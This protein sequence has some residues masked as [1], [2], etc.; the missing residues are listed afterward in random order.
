VGLP[1]GWKFWGTPLTRADSTAAK[2]DAQQAAAIGA[3]QEAT[4]KANAALSFAPESRPVTVARDFVQEARS[5]LDQV[6]GAPKVGDEAAWRDLVARLLSE[7]EAIRLKAET[8]RREDAEEVASLSAKLAKLEVAKEASD[9]K[10]AEY[11]KDNERLADIVRKFYWIA[12]SLAVLWLLSQVLTF[13]ARFN[14][15]LAP[16]AGVVNAVVAPALARARARAVEGLEAVGAGLRE[17]RQ[18]MG[19][20]VEQ[21]VVYLDEKAD[22]EHKDI[23]AKA[24]GNTTP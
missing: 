14:P 23:I 12:G 5:L 3:A 6:A 13:A 22:K 17:A 20:T 18:V 7:N 9:A 2:L 24:A 11:A 4:H 19:S 8:E 16:F 15:A 10:V 21:V 1:S